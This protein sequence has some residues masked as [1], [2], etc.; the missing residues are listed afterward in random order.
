VVS[1]FYNYAVGIAHAEPSQEYL[2][3]RHFHVAVLSAGVTVAL[4]TFELAVG[5]LY[6][7]WER[8]VAQ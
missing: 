2:I 6:G 8:E 5:E 7:E 4:V 1:V 3:S